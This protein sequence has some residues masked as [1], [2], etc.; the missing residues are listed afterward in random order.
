MAEIKLI[1]TG[2]PGA[3]KTTAI[4][5]ISETPPVTTDMATTD[6]LAAQKAAT[7]VAM[8]FGEITL[9]DGQK[10]HLYGTPGQRRFEFMWKII[11]QGGLGLILLLDNTRADPIA[12]MDMYLDNFSDFIR[13]TGAVI[14]VTRTDLRDTPA[15]DDYYDRLESRGEM[16]P[17][18]DADVRNPDDVLMLLDALISTLEYA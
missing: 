11:V 8:D 18:F 16:Y 14:G 7:T 2:T 4:G 10:V 3:G 15:L 5:A 1:F 13:E 9:D 17:V 12:D 6:E